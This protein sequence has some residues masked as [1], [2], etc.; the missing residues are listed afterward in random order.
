MN[1]C[2]WL[3]FFQNHGPN[4]YLPDLSVGPACLGISASGITH[5]IQPCI[6]LHASCSGLS[7]NFADCHNVTMVVTIQFNKIYWTNF[8]LYK[9]ISLWGYDEIMFFCLFFFQN[10]GPWSTRAE[11]LP[12]GNIPYKFRSTKTYWY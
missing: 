1:L 6:I 5:F 10:H 7:A 9:S 12:R 4:W 8:L 3:G 2:C 11:K